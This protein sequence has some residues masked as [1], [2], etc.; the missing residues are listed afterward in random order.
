MQTDHVAEYTQHIQELKALEHTLTSISKGKQF[1]TRIGK[2][3]SI[4]VTSVSGTW[5]VEV[6]AGIVLEKSSEEI[7]TLIQHQQTQLGSALE[8]RP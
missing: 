4:P 2:G 7:Q 1:I 8:H 6:G 5:Y 3:I